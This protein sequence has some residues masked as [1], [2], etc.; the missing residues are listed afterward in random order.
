MQQLNRRISKAAAVQS[1]EKKYSQLSEKLRDITAFVAGAGGAGSLMV[2]RLAQLGFGTIKVC[3]CNTVDINDLNCRFMADE[4][5]IGTNKAT[6]VQTTVTKM[7]PDVNIIPFTQRLSRANVDDIAGDAHIMFD[8]IDSRPADRFFLSECS[9]AK[10]I[11]HAIVSSSGFSAYAA[12][13]QPPQTACYHCI[14]DKNKHRVILSGLMENAEQNV[15]APRESLV[16][17]VSQGAEIAV[18]AAVNLLLEPQNNLDCRFFYF[19]QVSQSENFMHSTS[20]QW[21]TL[22]FSDH[23]KQLCLE[24]GFDWELGQGRKHLEEFSISPDPGCPICSS[25]ILEKGELL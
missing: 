12:V 19:N 2:Y 18:T 11:P 20:Y 21:M 23:F 22:L 10:G 17:L 14:F 8:T 15:Q 24:Q 1:T 3:D 5:H 7:R 13:F 25:E 9:A 4:T 16:F 6:S